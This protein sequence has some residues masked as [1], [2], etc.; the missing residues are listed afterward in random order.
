MPAKAVERLDELEALAESRF[1]APDTRLLAYVG[2]SD[3]DMIVYW[4]TRAIQEEFCTTA[5][6]GLLHQSKHEAFAGVRDDPEFRS[7]V[8]GI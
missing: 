8:E 7:L 3:A 4:L 1:L 5:C 2:S 6:W